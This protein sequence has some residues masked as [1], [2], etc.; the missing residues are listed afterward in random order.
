VPCCIV[1]N[2]LKNAWILE[3]FKNKAI[4][5]FLPFGLSTRLAHGRMQAKTA[6][7]AGFWA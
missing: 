2:V 6:S 4:C 3:G 5:I 1:F 7:W